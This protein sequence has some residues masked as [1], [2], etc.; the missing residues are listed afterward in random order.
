MPAFFFTSFTTSAIPDS[1]RPEPERSPS[2]VAHDAAVHALAHLYTEA[3]ALNNEWAEHASALDDERSVRERR[4]AELRAVVL[5]RRDQRRREGTKPMAILPATRADSKDDSG[6]NVVWPEQPA[7]VVAPLSPRRSAPDAAKSQ[8]SDRTPTTQLAASTSSSTSTWNGG[9]ASAPV[10]AAQARRIEPTSKTKSLLDIF[11]PATA[12]STTPQIPPTHPPDSDIDAR[13]ALLPQRRSTSTQPAPVPRP[14]ASATVAAAHITIKEEPASPSP[15]L[16]IVDLARHPL[17]LEDE[18]ERLRALLKTKAKKRK[19]PTTTP[20]ATASTPPR[21]ASATV[22]I[23]PATASSSSAFA[24]RTNSLPPKPAAVSVPS[25]LPQKPSAP[26]TSSTTTNP[27]HLPKPAQSVPTPTQAPAPLPTPVAAPAP[28]P[29]PAISLSL[30]LPAKPTSGPAPASRLAAFFGSSPEKEKQRESTT[31]VPI[32]KPPSG[33]P[34][35]SVMKSMIRPTSPGRRKPHVPR[36]AP[37]PVIGKSITEVLLATGDHRPMIGVG[38][39]RKGAVVPVAPLPLRSNTVKK[40]EEVPVQNARGGSAVPRVNGVEMLSL[41]TEIEAR[42]RSRSRSASVRRSRSRSHSVVPPSVEDLNASTSL[43]AFKRARSRDSAEPPAKRLK[44][45]VLAGIREESV[46]VDMEIER[47]E[48]DVIVYNPKEDAKSESAPSREGQGASRTDERGRQGTD[49]RAPSVS[50]RGRPR[51]PPIAPRGRGRG[52]GRGGPPPRTQTYRPPLSSRI[53]SASRSRSRSRSRSSDYRR[54]SS[55][56]YRRSRSRSR[57]PYGYRRSR[58]SYSRS[59]SPPPRG[60]RY[61]SRSRSPPRTYGN[62]YGGRSPPRLLR[63]M[64]R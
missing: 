61:Y 48:E 18:E 55:S 12:T 7:V 1:P 41:P 8:A 28:T 19:A 38:G 14:L 51:E 31:E 57:S 36:K 37:P 15:A 60:G 10:P 34:S 29:A 56:P 3:D 9:A 45:P 58:Y 40:Q 32:V 16:S 13:R 52:R 64:E 2:P 33:V 46:S 17:K 20:T 53:R 59:P 22:P 49:E 25:T 30:A 62:G 35:S 27:A 23:A 63:R 11:V 50:E 26:P 5:G 42:A 21:T 54:R 4:E 43:R 47:D 6:L 24:P 39:T 44:S